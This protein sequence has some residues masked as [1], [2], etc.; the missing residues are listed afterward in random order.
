M[1]RQA[2][3]VHSSSACRWATATAA[4]A[5]PTF[6]LVGPD[7]A[8]PVEL[9]EMFPTVTAVLRLKLGMWADNVVARLLADAEAQL[10]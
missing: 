3:A 8:L 7:G 5:R 9:R 10:R 1:G 6:Q 2:P 4:A